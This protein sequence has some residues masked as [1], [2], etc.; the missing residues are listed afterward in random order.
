M[1]SPFTLLDS[2]KYNFAD[3]LVYEGLI[4]F[5]VLNR[6]IESKRDMKDH[7]LQCWDS[8]QDAVECA[9]VQELHALHYIFP[10]VRREVKMNGQ[11]CDGRCTYL[12][13]EAKC[14]FPNECIN[15]TAVTQCDMDS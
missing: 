4:R 3:L 7:S 8:N 9:P 6:K 13:E 10:D 1:S 14:G 2:S 15:F 11:I 12:G 5:R